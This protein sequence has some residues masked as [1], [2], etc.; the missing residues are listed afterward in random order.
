MEER[1]AVSLTAFHLPRFA[2]I[3]KPGTYGSLGYAFAVGALARC[4]CV[5]STQSSLHG[6]MNAN[7]EG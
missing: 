5:D 4:L 6:R 1:I 7:G 2:W 3:L